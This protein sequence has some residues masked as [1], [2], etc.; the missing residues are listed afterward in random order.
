MSMLEPTVTVDVIRGQDA[1]RMLWQ[2]DVDVEDVE[3][4]FQALSHHLDG[5][6]SPV[7]V[8]IDL[9]NCVRFPLLATIECA[10]RG[11]AAHPQMGKWVVVGSSQLAR[12]FARTLINVTRPTSVRFLSE[13]GVLAERLDDLF[14]QLQGEASQAQAATK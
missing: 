7:H 9:Q 8:V 10:V 5:A 2:R 6:D 4:A 13:T 3:L 14:G 12:V 11:P 1:L